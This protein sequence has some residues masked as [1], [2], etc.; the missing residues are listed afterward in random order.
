[1]K[2]F[3]VQGG[4]EYNHLLYGIFS[5]RDLAM[6]FIAAKSPA[7]DDIPGEPY[8]VLVDEEV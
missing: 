3:L 4:H 6:G 2:V 5:T 1:M 8:E 7:N